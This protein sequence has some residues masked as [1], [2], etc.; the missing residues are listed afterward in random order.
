MNNHDSNC[1]VIVGIIMSS[2]AYGFLNGLTHGCLAMGLA[3]VVFGL[4]SKFLK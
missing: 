3:L 4:I 2:I 1:L